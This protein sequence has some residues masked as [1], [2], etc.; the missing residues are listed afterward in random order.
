M[1]DIINEGIFLE[2]IYSVQYCMEK[3]P[4]PGSILKKTD[5]RITK[6]RTDVDFGLC[7]ENLYY[8]I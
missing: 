3:F 2:W 4:I 5:S 1:K 6:K 7:Y 8:S